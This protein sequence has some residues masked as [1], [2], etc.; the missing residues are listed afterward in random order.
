MGYTGQSI[1]SRMIG[2]TFGWSGHP[3]WVV[4]VGT[5]PSE[6]PNSTR[7]PPP[8][9]FFCASTSFHYFAYLE[10]VSRNDLISNAVHM[11]PVV[12]LTQLS[13]IYSASCFKTGAAISEYPNRASSSIHERTICTGDPHD[14]YNVRNDR[15]NRC[16]AWTSPPHLT[17]QAACLH[18]LSPTPI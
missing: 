6:D 14:C 4:L 17:G 15:R 18:L 11:A 12:A 5:Q 10:H 16:L 8:P 3:V 7:V 13:L 1:V 2:L 9:Y